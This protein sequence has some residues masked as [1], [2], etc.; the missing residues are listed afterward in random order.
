MTDAGAKLPAWKIVFTSN[1]FY[2]SAF[3]LL[4]GAGLDNVNSRFIQILF[5]NRQPIPDTLFDLLP[6]APWTQYLT[7]I[8]NIFSCVLL[9][10]YLF[11]HRWRKLPQA[12]AVLGLGYT[13][14]SVLILLNPFGGWLG[15]NAHY[16]LSTIH[17]YGEFPS[18]HVFLVVAIY[19]LIDGANAKLLKRLALASVVVEIV[20]LLLSRGHYSADIVGGLLIGYFSYYILKKYKDLTIHTAGST[21]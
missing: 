13:I 18:G 2:A 20:T 16:G 3:L 14:R 21:I 7:D 4:V 9:A 1:V 6:Y 8:A 15:N 19:F 5:P 17:Q 11:P 10:I 12:L